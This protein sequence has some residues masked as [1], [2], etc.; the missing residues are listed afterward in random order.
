M[1]TLKDTKRTSKIRRSKTKG[2]VK[3]RVG[4]FDLVVRSE[5]VCSQVRRVWGE[6][7][8]G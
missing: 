8:T 7:Q 1:I 2:L 3:G 6:G 5:L 4:P